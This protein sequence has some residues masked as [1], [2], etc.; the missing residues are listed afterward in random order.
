[1]DGE[2]HFRQVRNWL[3]PEEMHKRD[4]YKMN[5][6]NNNNYSIIR[7]YQPDVYS[8]K[9]DW[10]NELVNS[11]QK[12]V[13]ANLKTIVPQVAQSFGDINKEVGPMV[14][15][16]MKLL[17]QAI[18][19]VDIDP[20][21]PSLIN[22][23][24]DAD[25]ATEVI[26]GL[27]GVTF[28]QEVDAATLS[29]IVPVLVLGFRAKQDST[30]RLSAVIVANMIK[31]VNDPLEVESYL[32]NLLPLLEN[33]AKNVSEPEAR[34]VCGK[35]LGQLQDIL[36]KIAELPKRV[37][38]E[39]PAGYARDLVQLLITAKDFEFDVWQDVLAGLLSAEEIAKIYGQFANLKV[40]DK[41]EDDDAAELLC[42]CEFTLAYGSKILLHNT[43][44]KLKR[45]YRYGLL[46][47][48]NSGKSTLLRAIANEQLEGF[49]PASQLRTVFV[50]TD[51]IGE[52]SHLSILEYIFADERVQN[53]GVNRE[54]IRKQLLDIGFTDRMI[55][56]SVSHISGGQRVKVALSRAMLLKSDIILMEEPTNHL[57]VINIAWVENYLKN[58]KDVTAIIVS[59]HRG[60]L[61]NCCTH[62]LHIDNYKLHLHR[63]N[64]SEFVK[65][66]PEALSYFEMK[67]KDTFKFKFPQP[68][69]LDG[70]KQLGTP[71]MKMDGVAFKYPTG[72]KNVI[73]NITVRVSM[74]SRVACCGI[75]GAGKSTMTKLLTGE[76]IPTEGTVWKKSGLRYAYIPQH[77]L[78]HIE[79]HLNKTPGEYLSWRFDKGVDKLI[80]EKD[81]YVMT[82]EEIAFCKEPKEIE[83]KDDKGNIK[84]VKWT[85][86][87]LTWER[88]TIGRDTYQYELKWE[89]GGTNYYDGDKLAEWGF[90]KIMRQVD[91]Q[92]E[93]DT[94]LFKRSL[95]AKAIEDH[96]RDFGLEPE[97]SMH[98]RM[99]A[100]SSSQKAKVVLATAVWQSPHLIILDEPSNYLDRDNIIS[101]A[102]GLKDYT[103]G[104]LIISHNAEFLNEICPETWTLENGTLNVKGDAS[105]FDTV[106][107]S[108]VN[109][110]VVDEIIDS[111]GNA[112]KIKAPKKVLS[113]KEKKIML[114]K[115]E[116]KLK[117]GMAFEDDEEELYYELKGE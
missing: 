84:K 48:N 31:L 40:E 94:G 51:I 104:V 24:R 13:R 90:T 21:I 95:S 14:E 96:F 35:A 52:L 42:D 114:K 15:D 87:K 27:A 88:K 23:F 99:S 63:G 81:T 106:A 74:A 107:K 113:N 103:G 9:Y 38:P 117:N 112:Q 12:E 72:E 102:E 91:L 33:A 30:K 77:S 76:L 54:D 22:V 101:L 26:H 8:N 58:L 3:P 69:Y 56:G 116:T 110:K 29:I 46:G 1:M 78:Y 20:F 2:Q 62:I 36:A 79:S 28:V 82:P 55:D 18:E 10:V 109:I 68:G 17:C 37:E 93:A 60:V 64:L 39:L 41:V 100:L 4:L 53:S 97:F 59:H 34:S 86:E 70:I 105:W 66:H 89:N 92:K 61:D 7:I 6:A 32:P 71:L 5:C 11:S 25:N 65:T 49:P 115:L 44:L 80:L 43:H 45:G 67:K 111:H 57:D 98:T 108:A 83:L 50:E 73:S 47:G 85:P 75:N 16:T 19:N